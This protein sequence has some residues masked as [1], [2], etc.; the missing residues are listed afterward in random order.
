M[1]RTEEFLDFVLDQLA[2]LEG[3]Y[4]RSMFGGH[5]LYLDETF[6]GIV[7]GERLYLK[8]DA[9]SRAKYVD[10]GMGPFRPNAKQMS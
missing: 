2:M 3:V 7:H 6:F 9:T 8:T 4:A 10:A 1:S 5:G